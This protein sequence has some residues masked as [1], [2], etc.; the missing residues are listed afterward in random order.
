MGAN[1]LIAEEYYNNEDMV[2]IYE[3]LEKVDWH[4]VIVIQI[5][6]NPSM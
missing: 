6:S 1:D 4:N 3:A 5:A 2:S